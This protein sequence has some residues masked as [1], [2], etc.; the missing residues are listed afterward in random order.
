MNQEDFNKICLLYQFLT[1]KSD[2][3]QNY[4]R[5][6]ICYNCEHYGVKNDYLEILKK[7]K[8]LTLR[9]LY[10][11]EYI[12]SIHFP[13]EYLD[14]ILVKIIK[15]K[16]YIHSELGSIIQSFL[17]YKLQEGINIFLQSLERIKNQYVGFVK[18]DK[19]CKIY[20]IKVFTYDEFI[21]QFENIKDFKLI[22]HLFTLKNINYLYLNWDKEV[23]I[24]ISKINKGLEKLINFNFQ[25]IQ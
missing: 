6:Y 1:K 24:D 16:V 11:S 3:N 18:T 15:D 17:I 9:H 8:K 2:F 23:E 7:F 5:W 12:N 20:K 14:D 10:T 19:D 13:D 25:S 21:P 4:D 22:F